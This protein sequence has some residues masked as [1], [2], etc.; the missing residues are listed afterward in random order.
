MAGAIPVRQRRAFDADPAVG[1]GVHDIH[2][3]RVPEERELTD[4]IDRALIAVPAHRL[5][6]NPDCGLKTRSWVEAGPALERMA[7][8]ARRVRENL[9][10]RD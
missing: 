2:A 8:A 5:W 9:P 10:A 7:A 1:P 3:P 4:L 6:I